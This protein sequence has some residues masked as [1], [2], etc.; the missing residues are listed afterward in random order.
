MRKAAAPAA[1]P[2]IVS[3]DAPRCPAAPALGLRGAAARTRRSG[4][5]RLLAALAHHHHAAER[6]VRAD[7]AACSLGSAC[8]LVERLLRGRVDDTNHAALAV[9][10]VGAVEEDRVGVV[11][12]NHEDVGLQIELADERLG[13]APMRCIAKTHGAARGLDHARV[14]AARRLR[15]TALGEVAGDDT[16]L[17][18]EEVV[19]DRVSLLSLDGVGREVLAVA[20]DLDLDRLGGG[21]CREERQDGGCEAGE[22]H[23]DRGIECGIDETDWY[24]EASY[25]VIED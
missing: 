14:E 15:S 20:A 19:L 7:V 9:I 16:V 3:N 23:L 25:R 24:Q 4:R 2:A 13:L 10:G 1:A 5:R 22:L 12:G 21:V 11:D 18:L 8:E 17:V 6:G